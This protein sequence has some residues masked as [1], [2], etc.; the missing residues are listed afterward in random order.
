MQ[1][2][3]KIQDFKDNQK[4]LDLKYEEFHKALEEAKLDWS[5]DKN[6][7]ISEYRSLLSKC[8]DGLKVVAFNDEMFTAL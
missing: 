6:K 4:K 8:E 3:L 7:S 2:Y 5:V 1:E